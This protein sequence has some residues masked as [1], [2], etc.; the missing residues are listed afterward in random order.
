MP[1]QNELIIHPAKASCLGFIIEDTQINL[2]TIVAS[3]I[4]MHVKQRRTSLSFPVLITELCKRARV[5]QD[6]KHDVE[7]MPTASADIWRIEDNCLKDQAERMKAASAPPPTPTPGPLGI[8]IATVTPTD[9]TG[10]SA[11]ILPR[12]PLT[13]VSLLR[14]GQLAF[15]ANHRATSLEAS[16][17]GMIQVA[18]T[19]VVTP[20]NTTIDALVA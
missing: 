16:I 14:M 15:F 18:Q 5:P 3:K 19:D 12:L 17:P 9:I 20:L 10:S 11:T 4:L 2:G 7:V 13:Q 6:T 8:P 1:S